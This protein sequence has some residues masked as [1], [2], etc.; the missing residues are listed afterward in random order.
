MIALDL[1]KANQWSE[2]ESL[3]RACLATCEHAKSD[4][5]TTFNTKSMLGAA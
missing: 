5:G 1:L 2:A 4:D 3:L